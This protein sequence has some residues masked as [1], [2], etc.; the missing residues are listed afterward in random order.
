M[1]P[2]YFAPISHWKEIVNGN[3]MWDL[4]QNFKKQ[5]LR[6]RTCIYGPNKIL[7]LSIPIKHSTNNF[8]L[9]DALIEND[10]SWQKEHWKSIESSYNSSPFF[11]YYKDSLKKI[12][13]NHYVK[14]S[15]FNF[16]C[17]NLISEWLEINKELNLTKSYKKKYENDIDLRKIS[18]KKNNDTFKVEKYI[19]VFS[20]KHGFKNNLSIL[21]LIFNQGPNSMS[22]LN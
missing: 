13:N 11:E 21:D 5:T 19:Q 22:Y 18:E 20:S 14:L 9:K 7:I 4:N 8:L 3:I 17:I 6:N 16:D 2:S 15:N 1:I 10:F 12:Y